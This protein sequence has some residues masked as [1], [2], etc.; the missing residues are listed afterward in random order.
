M[1]IMLIYFFAYFWT[2][3]QF[4][5]KEMAKNLRD[6][7][8][9]IPGLR[10]GRRTADY[11]EQVMERITYVGGAFLCVI[12]ALPT[13]MAQILEIPWAISAF[14][15]GTGLLIVISVA[16][17]LVNRIEASLIMRN[18]EGFLGDSAGRIRGAY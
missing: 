13:V 5:P 11:L 6:Y 16:L 12:A 4:Q 1:Y 14:L 9:F 3:V 15:G 17:D 10:P 8:S 18:Y 7:G 2:T